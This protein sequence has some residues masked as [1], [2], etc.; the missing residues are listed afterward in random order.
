MNGSYFFILLGI[1]QFSTNMLIANTKKS[2][3]CTRTMDFQNTHFPT[4]EIIMRL[5]QNRT[6]IDS[7]N[8][9]P[10]IP[11]EEKLRPWLMIASS[12]LR[13]GRTDTR[14]REP[15]NNKMSWLLFDPKHTLPTENNSPLWQRTKAIPGQ[16]TRKR[17]RI[18]RGTNSGQIRGRK[19][20]K[21]LFFLDKGIKKGDPH[22]FQP[23][24][25]DFLNEAELVFFE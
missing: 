22:W 24:L 3:I 1:P 16:I 15:G 10:R 12:K 7:K 13:K 25:N 5:T 9:N 6:L 14:N 21:R 18:N 20:R 19:N 23:P 17:L 8:E 2:S 4:T 11:E